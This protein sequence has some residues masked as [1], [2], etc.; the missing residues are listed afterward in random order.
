L[1]RQKADESD[2]GARASLEKQADDLLDKVKQIKQKASENA[3][4]S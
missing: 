3:A 2:A 1:L 4:K